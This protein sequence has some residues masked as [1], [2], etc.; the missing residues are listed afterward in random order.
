MH[1]TV[2]KLTLQH[3]QELGMQTNELILY[4]CYIQAL[5]NHISVPLCLLRIM[6]FPVTNSPI[7]PICGYP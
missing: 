1:T 5:L 3:R 2:D 4:S 7:A 6:L